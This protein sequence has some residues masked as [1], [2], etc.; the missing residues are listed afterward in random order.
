MSNED[1]KNMEELFQKSQDIREVDVSLLG[2]KY[3]I[4][5][6]ITLLSYIRNAIQ[7]N[8]KCKIEVNI[9]NNVNNRE[10]EFLVN[11]S[12]VDDLVIKESIEIN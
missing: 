8:T 12:K 10:F 2:N 3:T 6:I 9:G 11:N 1:I 4:I 7:N 5:Q